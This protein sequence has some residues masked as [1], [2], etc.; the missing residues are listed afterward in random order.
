[1]RQGTVAA[2]MGTEADLQLLHAKEL[3]PT[4]RSAQ[5]LLPAIADLLKQC[6]WQTNEIGLVSVT[7]GP[8]SFTGLRIGVTAAK[9][10][11]FAVSAAIVGVHTLAALAAGVGNRSGRLW[12]IMDAQ[13]QELFVASFPAGEAPGTPVTRIL[14]IDCW[15]T[16]LRAGDQ[17]VGPP[18]VQLADQLPAGVRPVD[19]RHW[20]PHA[21]VVGEL[22]Y[23]SYLA[24]NCVDPIQLVPNYYRKSAAEEKAARS[25]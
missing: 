6:Q 16:Q 23:A 7:T 4:E 14:A 18:L 15:L 9:T 25:E 5:T 13:R 19:P 12:S 17:V 1:M 22:G 21:S 3:P 10:L 20:Q 24:G 2:L 8:G 11:A